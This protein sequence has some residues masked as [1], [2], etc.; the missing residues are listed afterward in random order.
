MEDVSDGQ[1][2]LV[3]VAM[4]IKALD[5]ER[6]GRNA[7][8]T[9]LAG[10]ITEALESAMIDGKMRRAQGISQLHGVEM[11][12]SAIAKATLQYLHEHFDGHGASLPPQ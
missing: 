4:L 7:G 11:E 10:A 12:K 8:E 6:A 1:I 2:A 9:C 3:L 5:F